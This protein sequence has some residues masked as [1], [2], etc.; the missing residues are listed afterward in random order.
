MRRQLH[1]DP[2][3]RLLGLLRDLWGWSN[4][5]VHRHQLQSEN[6]QGHHLRP[7]VLLHVLHQQRRG[8]FIVSGSKPGRRHGD[9]EKGG[10]RGVRGLAFCVLLTVFLVNFACFLR[11]GTNLVMTS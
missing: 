8:L 6:R 1:L 9:W 5:W 4:L 11:K 3:D 7:H 10:G 2:L